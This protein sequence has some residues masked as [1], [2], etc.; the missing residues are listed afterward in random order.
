MDWQTILGFT[1]FWDTTFNLLA[2]FG[3][4]VFMIGI[5]WKGRQAELFLLGGLML[6]SFAVYG[7]NPIFTAAQTLMAVA[8]F[9]R[10][11][12]VAEARAITIFLTTLFVAGML[13][14]GLID[15]PLR[16]LGLAAALGLVF[17]VA[18]AQTVPGNLSFTA[19]GILM[20]LFAYLVWS[21]PFLALNMLFTTVVLIELGKQLLAVNR[22]R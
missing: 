2:Y 22:S 3:L 8:S 18:F 6:W 19:G 17:G 14:L 4:I 1:S 9:M 11:K 16:W 20:A 15:S 21:L 13:Y 12:R 7:H 10:L 5:I